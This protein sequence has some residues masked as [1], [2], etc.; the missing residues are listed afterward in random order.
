MNAIELLRSDQDRLEELFVNV[1]QTP[2]PT[3]RLILFRH[4]KDELLLYL[5]V[6][7]ISVYPVCA[8]QTD[9]SAIMQKGVSNHDAIQSL[10]VEVGEIAD[11]TEFNQKIESLIDL[12]RDHF[13]GEEKGLFLKMETALDEDELEDL[14]N[15]MIEAR[16]RLTPA[17]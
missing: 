11:E 4:I 8:E 10:I 6:E 15:A 13:Q 3:E 7:E 14:G 17:A 2:T 1:E 16:E 5:H 12:A 9:L